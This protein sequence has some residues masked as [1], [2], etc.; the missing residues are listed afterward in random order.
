MKD[1]SKSKIY[2]IVC[3]VTG[4]I[5]VGSTCEP[6]LARRLAKHV[7]SYKIWIKHNK[8]YMTSF[9]IIKSGNYD[10]I[11]VEECPCE[12]Q[13]QLHKRERHHIETIACVNKANPITTFLEKQEYKKQYYASNKERLAGQTKQYY[14]NNKIH[15]REHAKEKLKCECGSVF[16]REGKSVHFK[17]K[18]H[19]DFIKSEEV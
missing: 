4:L 6:T 1:Y 17:T 8:K 3:N 15:Y 10:I 16:A 11:L 14:E 12:T 5:Y 2:K 18:K 19:Q 9:E 7:G 13:D